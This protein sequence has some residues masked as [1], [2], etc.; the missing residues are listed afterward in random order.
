M[1]VAN[2]LKYHQLPMSG[3]D[4]DRIAEHFDSGKGK[5][6]INTIRGTFVLFEKTLPFWTRIP[7]QSEL[8]QRLIAFFKKRFALLHPGVDYRYPGSF[9][10]DVTEEE[11]REEGV[12]P[13]PLF[14]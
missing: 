2:N 12:S 3:V 1:D 8:G 14:P 5:Y 6:S 9:T 4:W 7:T 10:L 13:T 11:L